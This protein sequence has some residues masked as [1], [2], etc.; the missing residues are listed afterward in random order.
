MGSGTLPVIGAKRDDPVVM[1][2]S[3]CAPPTLEDTLELVTLAV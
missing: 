1:S 3:I 2:V